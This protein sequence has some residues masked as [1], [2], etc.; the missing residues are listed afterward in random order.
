[1]KS[2]M[3]DDFLFTSSAARQLYHEGAEHLPIF[4]YCSHVS[5]DAIALNNQFESLSQLLLAHDHYAWRLMLTDGVEEDKIRGTAPDREKFLAYAKVLQGAIGHPLYHWTH[6]ALRRIFDVNEP[7]NQSTAHHIWDECNEKL[8]SPEFSVQG[9]LTKFRVHT[10]CTAED[11]LSDLKAH[12]RIRSNAALQFKMR[13]TFCPDKALQIGQAGFTQ[14]ILKLGEIYGQSINNLQD[15]LSALEK[16][17]DYFHAAGCRSADHTMASPAQV[18]LDEEKADKAFRSALLGQ[19]LK[20]KQ[21]A[22]FQSL[23]YVALGQQYAKRNW[24]QQYHIGSIHNDSQRISALYGND[25][26]FDSV[27]DEPATR[28]L[29]Q[30]LDAQ[31]ATASLPR[32]VL[33]SVNPAQNLAIA[34]MISNFQQSGIPCKIQMGPPRRFHNQHEGIRDHLL[35]LA[36]ASL[37]KRHIGMTSDSPSFAGFSR[38]EYFRRILCE[39]IGNWV[40]YGEYP[41]DLPYLTDM[42]RDISFHNAVAFFP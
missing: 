27:T 15:L 41:N 4:D 3:G 28:N 31:D 12:Q 36:N 26:G 11:P 23:L 2:F 42:V 20:G 16:R 8:K 22:G 18:V 29:S 19:P 37:L 38:H 30:L 1:M 35:G 40:E 7:L 32:T 34:S 13:P 39:T 21:V 14:F 9:M 24:V 25:S 5:A 10:V 17:I 33:Y 6:L